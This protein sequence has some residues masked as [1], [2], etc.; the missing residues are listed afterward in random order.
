MPNN[1]PAYKR[2]IIHQHYWQSENSLKSAITQKIANIAL[3]SADHANSA[4]RV[5]EA[6]YEAAGRLSSRRQ[7]IGQILRIINKP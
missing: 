2:I 1:Y 3:I 4:I 6:Q 7:L 5:L